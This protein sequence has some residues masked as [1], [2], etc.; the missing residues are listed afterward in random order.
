MELCL[1][2]LS[3]SQMYNAYARKKRSSKKNCLLHNGE[4]HVTLCSLLKFK[5]HCVYNQIVYRFYNNSTSTISI[6]KHLLILLCDLGDKPDTRR[7]N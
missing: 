6:K 4:T 5:S 3:C 1:F 2:T 7:S